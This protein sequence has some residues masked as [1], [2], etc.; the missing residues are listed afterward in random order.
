MDITMQTASEMI[1]K[2]CNSEYK[3]TGLSGSTRVRYP[4]LT[5]PLSANRAWIPYT[6]II[7]YNTSIVWH[8][9]D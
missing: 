5:D 7:Y 9:P 6:M 8:M 1:F 4:T 2:K 3:G